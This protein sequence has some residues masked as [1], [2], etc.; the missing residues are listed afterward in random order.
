MESIAQHLNTAKHDGFI[1]VRGANENNL[2]N[3]EVRIPRDAIVAFTGVSG[4][5]KSS[6]AFG[7]IF[8]ESQRRFLESVA[9]YAR[10]LIAQGHSP[11]VEF[12]S[13][14]P[15]AVALQQRRGS[16]S[17][18]SSVGTL[19]TLSN[20]V[21][22]LFSRAGTYPDGASRLESDSFSRNTAV[23]ACPECHGVGTVHSVS[24]RSLVPD[25]TLSIRE[26][27]IAAWP[28]AWQGKNLRDITTHLGYDIDVPF[29]NLS[30]KTRD[31]LLFTEE[32]PVVEVTPE[33]DRVA[34]PYKGRFW[35]A[36]RYVRHTV[37]TSKSENL[38]TKALAFMI[39]QDC[40]QCSGTGFRNDSLK[41]LFAGLNIAEFNSRS[42]QS[43]AQ[44]LR[45]FAIDS[46]GQAQADVISTISTDLLARIQVLL[47]LGL[48]YLSLDRST[49][50]L[51]PGRCKDFAS[52]RNYAPAC[53]V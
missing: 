31:W 4:S 53:S 15:P 38:R 22:M 9:P 7:T 8:A 28:G 51:S 41:V 25:P 29:E 17:S 1:H 2:D 48:G 32:Q 40:V 10:R 42:L 49:P 23:G 16:A 12:I 6:L 5:G 13:G 52:P 3:V 35:S 14:L 44:L 11:K 26:G 18:R 43:L 37:A 47:E 20:S 19:T 34:K 36:E 24:E 50:T 21:R 30:K 27:A 45:P 33:R 39:S 46:E